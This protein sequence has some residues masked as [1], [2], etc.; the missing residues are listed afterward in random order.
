MSAERRDSQAY[1]GVGEICRGGEGHKEKNQNE[2]QD[3]PPLENSKRFYE[4]KGLKGAFLG[5]NW[6]GEKEGNF[7]RGEVQGKRPRRE[8]PDGRPFT[9]TRPSSP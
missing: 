1:G 9:P 6:L 3:I 7:L 2:A 4:S 8:R 5:E